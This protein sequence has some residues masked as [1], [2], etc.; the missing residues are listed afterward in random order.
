VVRRREE[1]K[2]TGVHVPWRIAPCACP[3]SREIARLALSIS[4]IARTLV[5]KCHFEHRGLRASRRRMSW[6][7]ALFN[8]EEAVEGEESKSEAIFTC[9]ASY[10]STGNTVFALQFEVYI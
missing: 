3:L 10:G 5:G 1:K 7:K 6:V 4:R 8:P 2:T 9:R